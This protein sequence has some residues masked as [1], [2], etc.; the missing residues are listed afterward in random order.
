M[1]ITNIG[2]PEAMNLSLKLG[3]ANIGNGQEIVVG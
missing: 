3:L 1:L 2:I